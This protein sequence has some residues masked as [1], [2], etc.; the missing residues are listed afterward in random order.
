MLPLPVKISN[1]RF[2]SLPGLGLGVL[3]IGLSGMPSAAFSD[4]AKLSKDKEQRVMAI[5]DPIDLHTQK[6]DVE[7]GEFLRKSFSANPNWKIIPRDTLV[8]KFKDYKLDTRNPCHEFQCAFD[9]GN[10]LSAEFVM[11][12]SVTSMDDLYAFTLNLV[13]VPTSQ[14][15]WSRVGEIRKRQLGTPS[16]AME[17]T[18]AQI[19]GDLGPDQVRTGRRDKRGL[20]TVLDLSAAGST[21]SRIMAERVATHL[22]ASRN[23]DIMG[24][25]EMEELLTALDINKGAF[26]PTDTGIYLLGGKMDIT[27]L[28]YSRLLATKSGGL[29]LQLALYDIAAR[30]KVREWPSQET[31]D[32]RKL[33]EF[34]DKFFSSLFKLPEYDGGSGAISS[35]RQ[36]TWAGAGLS[37][38]LGAAF[39]YLSYAASQDADR[40]YERFQAARSRETAESRQTKVQD[41]E[42][43]SVVYGVMGGLG[44]A[45]AGGFLM[46]SF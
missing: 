17:A 13:H 36:W 14:T 43:S 2:L 34:E 8:S 31:M 45:G 9:A 4:Q 21:P 18:L 27:H 15:V 32:F 19:A 35:G 24:K 22:Y 25:K 39:G 20:L 30:K 29:Q 10:I 41:K 28:V 1:M 33:L 46:F 38:A 16:S 42:R 26:N 44:L 37:L 6:I 40:E 3:L 23:Y 5:M 11:F 12:G 7:W